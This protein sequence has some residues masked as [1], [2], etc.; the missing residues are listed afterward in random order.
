LGL[1]LYNLQFQLDKTFY[2]EEIVKIGLKSF[3]EF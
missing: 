1:L 2:L 3:P